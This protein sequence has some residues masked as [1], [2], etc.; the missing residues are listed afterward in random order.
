MTPLA[1]SEWHLRL[2]CANLVSC[3]LET[4]NLS[5]KEEL[6]WSRKTVK[7]AKRQESSTTSN[8]GFE[9]DFLLSDQEDVK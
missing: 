1:S 4:S 5:F 8:V 3:T 6:Q 7:M 9:E 2:E